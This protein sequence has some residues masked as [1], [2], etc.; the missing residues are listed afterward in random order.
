MPSTSKPWVGQHYAGKD[1]AVELE[2]AHG[3]LRH[4]LARFRRR[5]CVVSRSKEMVDRSIALAAHLH[6]NRDVDPRYCYLP[7]E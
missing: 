1:Q 7:L 2:R 5:T 6:I 3:R 4:W